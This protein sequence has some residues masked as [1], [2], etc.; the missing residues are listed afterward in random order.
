VDFIDKKLTKEDI[1][2]LRRKYGDYIKLTIDVEKKWVVAGGKLHADAEQILLEKGSRGDDIWGGG[3]NLIDNQV[4][5][6][7]VLNIRPRLGNDSMEI[8][9]PKIRKKFHAIIKK[10]FVGYGTK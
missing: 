1:S 8:L 4:D 10:Y 3:V 2:R 9:S 5:T 6:M 7:A